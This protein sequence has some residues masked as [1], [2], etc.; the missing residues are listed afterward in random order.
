MRRWSIRFKRNSRYWRWFKVN[1]VW[2][3]KFEGA[4]VVCMH[5]DHGSLEH[6]CQSDIDEHNHLVRGIA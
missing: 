1:H 4:Y 6:P 2:E 3:S 5:C